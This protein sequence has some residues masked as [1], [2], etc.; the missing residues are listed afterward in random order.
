MSEMKSS[1]GGD[2]S[3]VMVG[4]SAKPEGVGFG[5]GKFLF[6]TAIRVGLICG[7]RCRT[8]VCTRLHETK[9]PTQMA[10]PTPY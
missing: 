5:V 8:V 2:G 9:W 4:C 10:K 6:E 1:I 7:A 3:K